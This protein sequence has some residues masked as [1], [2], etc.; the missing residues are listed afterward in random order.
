MHKKKKCQ[1]KR[2][3]NCFIMLHQV[4][5]CAR[6]VLMQAKKGSRVQLRVQLFFYQQIENQIHGFTILDGKFVLIKDRC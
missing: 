3:K 6:C 5:T 1:G 2:K 4:Q